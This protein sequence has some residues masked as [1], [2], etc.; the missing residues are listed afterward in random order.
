MDALLDSEMQQQVLIM[1]QE[2]GFRYVRVWN[3]FVQDMY[4][5]KDGSWHYNFSRVD[6]GLD[7]LVENQ[8]KPYIEL[9]LNRFMLVIRCIQHLQKR[10]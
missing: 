9:S 1:K 4:E 6:R 10:E 8:L 7:F 3:I 2:L 5:E